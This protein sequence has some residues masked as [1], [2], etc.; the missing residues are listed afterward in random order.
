MVGISHRLQ[1]ESRKTL[2]KM[3]CACGVKGEL[4]CSAL[5]QAYKIQCRV[6]G[7]ER[8]SR[9]AAA[10]LQGSRCATHG[11]GWEREKRTPK[12]A[13]T[14]LFVYVEKTEHG[15]SCPCL[16]DATNENG[17]ELLIL[18]TNASESFDF[19]AKRSPI[20]LV[21][22]DFRKSFFIKFRCSVEHARLAAHQ[23][24]ADA[25]SL[26]RRKDF[27]CRVRVQES[28]QVSGKYA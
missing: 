7:M 19:F 13:R 15:H 11:A 8:G 24:A 4:L 26:H 25:M 3:R 22:S 23:Q 1:I 10:L 12:G 28:L 21:C 14:L 16:S 17:I 9:D 5:R 20:C 27:Q 6:V 2:E 18:W